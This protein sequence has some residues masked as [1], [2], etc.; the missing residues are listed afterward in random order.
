MAQLLDLPAEVLHNIYDWLRLIEFSD[1]HWSQTRN[2]PPGRF[3]WQFNSNA[4]QPYTQA[5]RFHTV[6]IS[7]YT[8]WQQFALAIQESPWLG[9]AVRNLVLDGTSYRLYMRPSGEQDGVPVGGDVWERMKQVRSIKIWSFDRGFDGLVGA[10]EGG[11]ELPFLRSLELG[12]SFPGGANP[13]ELGTWR[14][15]LDAAPALQQLHVSFNPGE[16]G[17]PTAWVVPLAAPV[18]LRTRL[19][20]LKVDYPYGTHEPA[21]ASFVNAFAH[22]ESLEVGAPN[23]WHEPRVLGMLS[24]PK[25]R[26]I[27]FRWHVREV[28]APAALGTIDFRHL[29]SLEHVIIETNYCAG[30]FHLHL[31]PSTSRLTVDRHNNVP[32]AALVELI[33][34]GSPFHHPTLDHLEL[35]LPYGGSQGAEIQFMTIEEL[36]QLALKEDGLMEWNEDVSEESLEELLRVAEAGGVGVSGNCRAVWKFAEAFK[37]E[38]ERLEMQWRKEEAEGWGDDF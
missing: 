17:N 8:S 20:A 15:L 30:I 27:A 31:P 35:N 34:P 10:A 25:L 6:V 24:L 12:P 37:L 18:P 5:Y 19:A 33:M 21:L 26:R 14:T 7:K 36:C 2:A 3:S 4:L 16:L 1:K 38:E 13:Y 9:G 32:L 23:G 11:L 28:T 29:S 22:L